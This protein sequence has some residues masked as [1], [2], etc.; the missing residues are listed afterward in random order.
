V[1]LLLKNVLFTLVVP[2]TVGIYLPLILARGLP[3][4]L[5]LT[6]P[7]ALGFFAIATALY[8]WSLW[9]FA[10]RGRGTPLPADAPKRL[11]IQ[12]PY[13][14]TRN[15]MYLSLFTALLGWLL[16]Y[17]SIGILLYA[18]VAA[19]VVGFF[20]V[21]YEE[22]HLQREFGADYDDYKAKVPRWLPRLRR[23]PV[24]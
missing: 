10:T 7:V 5:G 21:R 6:L 2:G 13:L 20:V 16:L 9:N 11:V 3:V 17:Q 14:Y 4:N 18:L 23:S 12:G 24:A 22:P 8:L 15:P 19:V 1:S